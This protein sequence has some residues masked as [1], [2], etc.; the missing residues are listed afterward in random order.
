MG[1]LSRIECESAILRK[2]KEIIDIYHEYNPDG[3][4]ISLCMTNNESIH[5]NNISY[6]D[7]KAI[8][9]F[10]SDRNGN[11]ALGTVFKSGNNP[12]AHYIEFDIRDAS[13]V[14]GD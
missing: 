1:K 6:E 9:C 10:M 14:S 8:H 3:D 12:I 2:M 13:L 11:N 5:V 7:G 4:Y